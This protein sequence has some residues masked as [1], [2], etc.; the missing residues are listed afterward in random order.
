MM[1]T[2]HVSFRGCT[3][4]YCRFL[5]STE[6]SP[7]HARSLRVIIQNVGSH[8]TMQNDRASQNDNTEN[9]PIEIIAQNFCKAIGFANLL[10]EIRRTIY[11]KRIS[12]V[13]ESKGSDSNSEPNKKTLPSDSWGNEACRPLFLPMATCLL[14]Y[15]AR[16]KG[17]QG[18][19]SIIVST[20]ASPWNI[21][22]VVLN[23][24]LL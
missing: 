12:H 1:T 17:L 19:E 10:P 2:F 7:V 11:S 6:A 4:S 15:P 22:C 23:S 18:K 8:Q 24:C 20:T 5:Q 14:S 13:S 16:L 21:V 3:L 9:H